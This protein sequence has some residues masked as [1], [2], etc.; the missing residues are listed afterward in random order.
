[1]PLDFTTFGEGVIRLSVPAGQRIETASRF[2]VG[3]SGAEGLT[4]AALSRL[5]WRCGWH[6]ALPDIP[7]GRLVAQYF[8]S[9]GVDLSSVIWRSKGRVSSYYVEFAH[10]PRPTMVYYDRKD[11]C[12]TNLT[13]R[14]IDWDKFLDTKHIHLSGMTVP[15]SQGAKDI[16]VDALSRA[17]E[18]GITTSFDVNYR[19][20]LWS[21]AEALANLT[22]LVKGVDILFLSRRDADNVF[23]CDG[24]PK[25][26][27]LR[28][29]DMTGARNIVMSLSDEGV[30]GWD[31]ETVQREDARNVTIIDRIGAGDAMMAG[32]LHGWFRGSLHQ[33][34]QYGAVMAALA[35]SQNG[36]AVITDEAELEHLL[37]ADPVDIVR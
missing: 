31:G 19:Q 22:D 11:S 13:P 5:G 24:D 17:R 7:P 29:S 37:S 35:L 12:F 33:G 4:A 2:D 6:S 23:G 10:P 14:D 34:L 26:V 18:Q 32:V 1:M 28:L 27:I 15:L 8:R 30:I 9:H 21:P 36:N 3:I 25:S 20:L 16:I